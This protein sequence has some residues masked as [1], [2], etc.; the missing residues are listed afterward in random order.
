MRLR[1]LTAAGAVAVLAAAVSTTITPGHAVAAKR[2]GSA[3]VAWAPASSAQV[4]PGVMTDTDGAQCTANFVF[5]DG[6]S[7]YIGQAAHCSGTGAATETD[8][9]DSGSLP[10]GTPV[11]VAGYTGTMVYNSWLA[12]Q[13]AGEK[14]A[15]TCAYN[16]LALIK[17]PT[18]AVATTNPSVPFWG[19]PVGLGAGTTSGED[20]YSYQNSSLRL[21]L[22]PLSPKRGTSL[23]DTEG[24][25]STTVYTVTPGIPGDSGSGFLDSAGRAFGVLS[26]VA[27]APLPA[28]NGVGKLAKE[29]AYA[30]TH[31]VPGLTLV[32]GTEP[33]DPSRV[34][35]GRSP[36]VDRGTL[37]RVPRSASASA[38]LSVRPGGDS[39]PT[40]F[41][42]AVLE[43]VA[44]IPAGKVMT[45]GDVAEYLGQ[46][47][48]R[49][50]GTVMSK[51]GH[52]VPWQR[53]VQA[54]GRPAEPL[55][56]KALRI[57]Q[58][59]GCPVR[60]ERVVLAEARWDGR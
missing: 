28:S 58:A 42:L 51:H 30:Q 32:A 6:T 56:E 55:L 8:G 49:T 1:A 17:L 25:W 23:G 20:V 37:L 53:V 29:V 27:I 38:G 57:L 12:M 19:G 22:S 43:V 35:Y 13:K 39:G 4:H 34:L 36:L 24:G 11:D 31:G 45:Y 47:S 59:E 7:T 5:T 60:G 15:E 41:A 10:L 46:G 14:D 50:V 48:P 18:A 2:T 26:T 21:G 9:C 16:D 54:S 33:F 44:R 3:T 52:E 40:P